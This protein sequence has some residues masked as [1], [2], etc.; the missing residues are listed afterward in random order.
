[1]RSG[2]DRRNAVSRLDPLQRG[3]RER[4]RKARTKTGRL[5]AYGSG[6]LFVLM[7]VL[8]AFAMVCSFFDASVA[9]HRKQAVTLRRARVSDR[10]KLPLTGSP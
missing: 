4:L 10:R 6:A 2:G 1:L 8:L 5:F 9:N 3:H 7:L